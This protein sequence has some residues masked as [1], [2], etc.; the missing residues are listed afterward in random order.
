MYVKHVLLYKIL[1]AAAFVHVAARTTHCKEMNRPCLPFAGHRNNRKAFANTSTKSSRKLYT[2][3]NHL[4]QTGHIRI[5]F[6]LFC[7]GRLD[8]KVASSVFGVCLPPWQSPHHKWCHACPITFCI[9]KHG[10]HGQSLPKRSRSSRSPVVLSKFFTKTCKQPIYR[11]RLVEFASLDIDRS[12]LNSGSAA[13]SSPGVNPFLPCVSL[14]SN[15]LLCFA[16]L[17]V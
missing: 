4:E 10:N 8:A 3:H 16:C 2:L 11:K 17:I 5:L 14:G 1:Q 13:V 9:Q 6:V 15:L 7:P 12:G